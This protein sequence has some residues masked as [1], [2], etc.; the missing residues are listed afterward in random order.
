MNKIHSA[1]M[2]ARRAN[3]ASSR[4]RSQ[5][6]RQKSFYESEV[7]VAS[8]DSEMTS[9]P[10]SASPQPNSD[11]V[12]ADYVLCYL[13][14]DIKNSTEPPELPNKKDQ[15]FVLNKQRLVFLENL[16]NYGCEIEQVI[17]SQ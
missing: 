14:K 1:E 5:S 16:A 13:A 4:A 15:S 2:V 9:R 11:S 10:N 8:F 3:R 7:S 6:R 12:K 17:I